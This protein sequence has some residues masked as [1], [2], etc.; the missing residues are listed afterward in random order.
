VAR[1]VWQDEREREKHEGEG[2]R[3]GEGEGE[4]GREREEERERERARD[5]RRH[6][7]N[8]PCQALTKP[9]SM[10]KTPSTKQSCSY[11]SGRHL[12]PQSRLSRRSI[13]DKG[14]KLT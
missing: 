6:R 14:S 11:S 4:G 1:P 7:R 9:A 8:P 13:S 10:L 12:A 3:E 5:I 2:E